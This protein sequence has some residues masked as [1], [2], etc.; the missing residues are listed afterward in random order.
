MNLETL[1]KILRRL[2]ADKFVKEALRMV[3][4]GTMPDAELLRRCGLRVVGTEVVA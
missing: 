4:D 3:A 1:A 2:P